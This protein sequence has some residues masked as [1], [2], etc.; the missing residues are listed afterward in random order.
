MTRCALLSRKYKSCVI[1]S[2]DIFSLSEMYSI[3]AAHV[4]DLQATLNSVL[5]FVT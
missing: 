1:Q 5:W 2:V 4:H 3:F